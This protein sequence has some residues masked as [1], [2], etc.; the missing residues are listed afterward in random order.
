MLR[1]AKVW[2]DVELCLLS[3]LARSPPK[4]TALLHPA[5]HSSAPHGLEE[6]MYARKPVKSCHG[7][8][9]GPGAVQYHITPRWAKGSLVTCRRTFW[10]QKNMLRVGCGV[11]VC[12]MHM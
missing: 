7:T 4:W 1:L 8:S 12:C 11:H 3:L 5:E 2:P 10:E 9:Q 6:I